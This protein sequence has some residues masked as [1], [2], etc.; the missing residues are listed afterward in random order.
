MPIRY[1]TLILMVFILLYGILSL[2]ALGRFAV[3]SNMGDSWRGAALFDMTEGTADRPYVYR[4]LVPQIVGVV[5]HIA[6]QSVQDAVGQALMP[7]KDN[8]ILGAFIQEKPLLR[9][10]FEQPHLLFMRAEAGQLD[11]VLRV[12][13]P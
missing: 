6:P 9:S 13:N 10:A 1:R 11:S 2:Y 5:V 12:P 7:L 3:A 8:K 4:V